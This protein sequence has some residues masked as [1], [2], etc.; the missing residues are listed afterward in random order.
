MQPSDW[1]SVKSKR[2]YKEAVGLEFFDHY[3]SLPEALR[4]TYP[5]TSWDESQF[6]TLRPPPRYWEDISRQ[7]RLL[8]NI[9]KKLGVQQV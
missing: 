6:K 7:R 2:F 3:S 9:G 8:D 4:E 1:Y 5:T